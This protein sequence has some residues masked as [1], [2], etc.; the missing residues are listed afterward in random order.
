MN[1]RQNDQE[2]QKVEAFCVAHLAVGAHP[3]FRLPMAAGRPPRSFRAGDASE[4]PG[5]WKKRQ[6]STWS[7]IRIHRPPSRYG[8]RASSLRTIRP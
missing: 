6:P 2:R 7:P 5:G 1:H 8:A 4:R 3:R